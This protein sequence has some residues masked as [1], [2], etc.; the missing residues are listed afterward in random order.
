MPVDVVEMKGK[1][2]CSFVSE[3]PSRAAP[4]WPWPSRAAPARPWRSP[5]SLPE[6]G[7]R[8]PEWYVLSACEPARLGFLWPFLASVPTSG[9]HE[10]MSRSLCT[11]TPAGFPL[12]GCAGNGF[13]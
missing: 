9:C 2:R 12:R 3:W 10:S 1:F 6:Q 5:G 11:S 7:T 13:S 4:A 8:D